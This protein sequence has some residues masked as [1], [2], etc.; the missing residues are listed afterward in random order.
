MPTPVEGAATIME[1]DDYT[2]EE[3]YANPIYM[4][5]DGR[6]NVFSWLY[7]FLSIVAYNRGFQW[8]SYPHAEPARD[9]ERAT[10]E[11]CYSMSID[12]SELAL[13]RSYYQLAKVV[14]YLVSGA[15]AAQAFGLPAAVTLQGVGGMLHVSLAEHVRIYRGSQVIIYPFGREHTLSH[16]SG[17]IVKLYAPCCWL[18]PGLEG[19]RAT[20][21]AYLMFPSTLLPGMAARNIYHVL[22]A[23]LP[24]VFAT[25]DLFGNYSFNLECQL[26]GGHCYEGERYRKTH[27]LYVHTNMK[28]VF[29]DYV[30]GGELTPYVLL[31]CLLYVS[32]K[33]ASE[34]LNKGTS[35]T[36]YFGSTMLSAALRLTHAETAAEVEQ[37]KFA[38]HQE[39]DTG[40]ILENLV[41]A[42]ACPMSA[43]ATPLHVLHNTS[44]YPAD[45][46][47][48]PVSLRYLEKVGVLNM[49]YT[50]VNIHNW[51]TQVA[52]YSNVDF[53][54]PAGTPAAAALDS[55]NAE[56]A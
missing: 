55:L 56:E 3:A 19:P 17:V 38:T 16:F 26:A 9:A 45:F 46:Y 30:P 22:E 14:F 11:D 1:N 7:R 51:S 15:L 43:T 21:L 40:P 49:A 29:E 44:G 41:Q 31:T 23:I 50:S 25:R 36:R 35:R 13:T 39:T 47:P 24:G 42:Y 6:P 2:V 52:D 34:A 54:E 10:V 33:A 5:P 32:P 18:L 4:I 8:R 28:S 27:V 12:E 53:V 37:W 20:N 48:V